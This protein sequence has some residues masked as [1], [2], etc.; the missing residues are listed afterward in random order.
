MSL[1]DKYRKASKALD[2]Q[3][4][5]DTAAC[6]KSFDEAITEELVENYIDTHSW[7]M[8]MYMRN[9]KVEVMHIQ[10][11]KRISA[12]GHAYELPR[13]DERTVS[14]SLMRVKD[15]LKDKLTS[16]G[17]EYS[18]MDT[19]NQTEHCRVIIFKF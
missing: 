9:L 2:T 7:C 15:L 5:E 8:D 12:L 11:T 14:L 3:R 17:F 18:R 4:E 13:Y 19:C 1:A 10:N 6:L 16:Y